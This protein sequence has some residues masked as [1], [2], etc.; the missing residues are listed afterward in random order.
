LTSE[1]KKT[2]ENEAPQAVPEDAKLIPI[3]YEFPGDTVSSKF[4]NHVVVQNEGSEVYIS[5]FEIQPPMLTGT[6]ETRRKK[7]QE[8]DSVTARCV[9]RVII[10]TARLPSLINVLTEQLTRAEAKRKNG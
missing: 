7:I 1:S 6:E 9:T 2:S 3:E 8:L 4:S 10:T 5:F